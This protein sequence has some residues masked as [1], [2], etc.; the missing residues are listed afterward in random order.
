MP[1]CSRQLRSLLKGKAQVYKS[2]RI[3]PPSILPLEPEDG[4]KFV[5]KLNLVV[6]SSANN[7]FL[8]KDILDCNTLEL[9]RQLCIMYTTAYDKIN[10][11]QDQFL[12]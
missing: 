1:A 4:K 12:T 11:K 10:V 2:N 7:A 3:T 5:R 6:L 9:G 8:F